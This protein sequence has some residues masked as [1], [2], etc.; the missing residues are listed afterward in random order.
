[1]SGEC[2]GWRATHT[3]TSRRVEGV[4]LCQLL[5]QGPHQTLAGRVDWGEQMGT[6]EFAAKKC[7]NSKEREKCVFVGNR[8]VKENMS[9]LLELN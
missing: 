7:K 2:V 8:N 9:P 1:M 3:A 4:Q 5:L 6:S